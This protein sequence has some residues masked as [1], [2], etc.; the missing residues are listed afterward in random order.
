[1]FSKA[2]SLLYIMVAGAMYHW[3]RWHAMS[4]EMLSEA[5]NSHLLRNWAQRILR[6]SHII[7]AFIFYTSE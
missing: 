1:M 7:F 5:C 2:L 4:G 6:K 3:T